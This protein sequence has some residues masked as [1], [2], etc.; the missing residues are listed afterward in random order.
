MGANQ[1]A[2]HWDAEAGI[3][4]LGL[5]SLRE[6][7][8]PLWLQSKQGSLSHTGP[9]Q[10]EAVTCTVTQWKL[11]DLQPGAVGQSQEESH[12]DLDTLESQ[13]HT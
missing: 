12:Q 4:K 10:A 1:L 9:T 3:T 13:V 6:A 11:M 5:M 8:A 7:G 2:W